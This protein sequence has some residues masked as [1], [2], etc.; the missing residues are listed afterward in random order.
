MSRSQLHWWQLMQDP[1]RVGEADQR[2]LTALE[3]VLSL[4]PYALNH[5]PAID[6]FQRW[7]ARGRELGLLTGAEHSWLARELVAAGLK[8]GET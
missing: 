1:A 4:V 5:D 8:R 2:L 3:E 6:V 7:L